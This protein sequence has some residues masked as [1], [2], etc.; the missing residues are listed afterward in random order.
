M[1]RRQ[2][3]VSLLSVEQ[4]E[5]ERD[6]L[7]HQSRYKK[8]LRSTVAILVVVAAAAVLVAM[9]WMP[10]LRICGTSMEPTLQD[11]QIVVTVKG[12]SFEPGDVVAFYHGNTLLIKRYIAGPGQW[13]DIDDDGNVSVDG[14]LLDEPYI[15]E[16]AYGETNIKLPYQ[17]PEKRFFLMGDNRDVSVDSRNTTV[18][19]VSS[20]QIVG[21]VVFCIWPLSSFGP[22]K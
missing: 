3:D 18:G 1:R 10:V 22:V 2:H 13:V 21:K 5:Q 15:A 4:I 12:N 9:L 11:G 17:V 8:T 19:C 20:E 14:T 16:K 6:R 7:H